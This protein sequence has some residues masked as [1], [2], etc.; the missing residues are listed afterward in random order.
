MQEGLRPSYK[1]RKL[2]GNLPIQEGLRL[3]YKLRKLMG[4]PPR[5]IFYW[6]IWWPSYMLGPVPGEI[7][8]VRVTA[9]G[10]SAPSATISN[11]TSMWISNLVN[12]AT[13]VVLFIKPE[14]NPYFGAVCAMCE[15]ARTSVTDV[16]NSIRICSRCA[17]W[18]QE[19]P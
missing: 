18:L 1:L 15:D 4:N 16:F 5:D 8:R 11:I 17:A 2:M 13:D 19:N 10:T 3:G 12:P 6:H 14:K 7:L 9:D